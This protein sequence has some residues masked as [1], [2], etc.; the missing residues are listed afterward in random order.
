MS[1]NEQTPASQP[2][3]VMR[4]TLGKEQVSQDL[5]GPAFDAALREYCD[6]NYRQL[7]PI[8]TEKVHQEKEHKAE[9]EASRKGL[10]PN[11]SAACPDALNQGAVIPSHQGKEVRKGN[12]VQ[13]AEKGVFHK[14]GDKVK[15]T[16]AHSNDSRR[17]SYY[18]SRRD[19]K[20]CYHSSHLKETKFAFEK[21]HNKKASLRR[22]KALSQIED[23][24]GGH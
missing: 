24:A 10:D 11:M 23:S 1:T 12:D 21:R 8:I 20:R 22:R 2:T 14:L 4:N 7:L 16:S 9:E 3:S 17:R 15:S 18:S 6:R 13:K 19:T 5:G